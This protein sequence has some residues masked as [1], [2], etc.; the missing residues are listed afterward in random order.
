MP[1][2]R[3]HSERFMS[4]QRYEKSEKFVTAADR[5]VIAEVFWNLEN[6][7]HNDICSYS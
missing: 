4:R 7:R 3:N 6:R 2:V 5:L 1:S